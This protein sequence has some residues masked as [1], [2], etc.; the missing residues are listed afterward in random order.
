MLSLS[1]TSRL[2][3]YLKTEHATALTQ[4]WL[5][6]MNYW[7]HTILSYFM[8]AKVRMISDENQQSEMLAAAIELGLPFR[9]QTTLLTLVHRALQ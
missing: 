6:N 7:I 4:F 8:T 9:E 1:F 2:T 5:L 3:T